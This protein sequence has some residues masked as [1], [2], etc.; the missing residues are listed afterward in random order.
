MINVTLIALAKSRIERGASHQPAFMSGCL[1][2]SHTCLPCLP[3]EITFL[4]WQD[5]FAVGGRWAGKGWRV[6]TGKVGKVYELSEVARWERWENSEVAQSERWEDSEVAIWERWGL[7]RWQGRKDGKV[8]R[9]QGGRF[10]VLF[11][12]G[13]RR[14]RPRFHLVWWHEVKEHD[15]F[16][17]FWYGRRDGKI[18]RESNASC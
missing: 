9:W 16:T 13:G 1:T 12:G 3:S 7:V 10:T 11:K 18:L 15:V 8:V 5:L 2:I 4:F 17:I 14:V 6:V